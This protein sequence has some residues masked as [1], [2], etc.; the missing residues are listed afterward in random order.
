MQKLNEDNAIGVESYAKALLNILSDFTEEKDRLHEAQEATLNIL[1]DLYGEKADVEAAYAAMVNILEDSS[2]EKGYLAET[3][4]AALNILDDLYAERS[5]V[6]FTSRAV[7]NILGDFS[8]EKEHLNDSQ[9]ATLNILEDFDTERRKM[10][11]ANV[12]LGRLSE[13]MTRSNQ[14]L[15]Q[16]AYAASHDL[17]EPL[18][19][20][21]SYVTLLEERYKGKLDSKA[22]KYI[23]YTVDASIRMDAL[24]IGLLEFSRLSRMQDVFKV[25]DL[26][27]VIREVLLNLDSSILGCGAIVTRDPLPEIVGVKMGITSLFQNLIANAIKFRRGVPPQVHIAVKKEEG[28]WLF[29]I[30]DNG[31]GM[32]REHFDRI[33]KIFQRLHTREAYPGTGIGLS[34]C[35]KVVEYHG[36]KIWVE[37]RV[38]EGTTF[39]FTLS[40]H[41]ENPK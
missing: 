5:Q 39:F 11:H 24:V 29:T 19:V 31:I 40:D 21:R 17:R 33:F 41:L 28:T 6:G 12:E 2:T 37:S 36:G 10:E 27:V 20:I 4:S 13:A 30:K 38:G 15:E 25:V 22:D 23:R 16:F 7:M 35:K 14:D 32:E 8:E 3:Q 34:L 18:R 26:E 9:S 1:D